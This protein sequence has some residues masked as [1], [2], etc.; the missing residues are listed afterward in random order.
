[1]PRRAPAPEP[2]VA[3]ETLPVG[4]LPRVRC[5]DNL[6][7]LVGPASS[8]QMG[9]QVSSDQ[10]RCGLDVAR[11][12]RPAAALYWLTR[13]AMMIPQSHPSVISNNFCGRNPIIRV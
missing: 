1:M 11:P 13:N 4:R 10:C 2:A 9:D 5:T 12:E 6:P 8:N 7:A 3:A